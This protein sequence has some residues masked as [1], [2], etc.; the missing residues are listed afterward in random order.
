MR[1]SHM[2]EP[3]AVPRVFTFVVRF[4]KEC[5]ATGLRWR[6]RIQHVESGNSVSFIDVR[7]MLRFLC[8]SGV[9]AED[10]CLPVEQE[11]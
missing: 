6:G 1:G 2:T 3:S 7:K 10:E 8:C 9:M 11:E 4:W 5:S